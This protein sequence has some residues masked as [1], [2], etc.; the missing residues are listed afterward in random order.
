MSSNFDFS[1]WLDEAVRTRMMFPYEEPETGKPVTPQQAGYKDAAGFPVMDKPGF[2]R[3][4]MS[5]IRRW[6]P[7]VEQQLDK[8]TANLGVHWV[9]LYL[10]PKPDMPTIDKP[11]QPIPSARQAREM[12]GAG[13][14]M[15]E[16]YSHGVAK[17]ELWDFVK[18]QEQPPPSPNNTIVYVK[19]TSRVHALS[20]WQLEHN[21]GHAVWGYA[22]MS[23]GGHLKAKFVKT[24]RQIIYDLQQKAY[25]A[26]GPLPNAKEI[27]IVLAR[28]LKQGAAFRRCFQAKAG[29]LDKPQFR[30]N[31]AFNSFDEAMFDLV[32][33][34]INAGGRIPVDLSGV[35]QS[36]SG[37]SPRSGELPPHPEIE[38]KFQ[39]R[40]W[41]WQKLASDQSAWQEASNKLSAIVGEAIQACV[42]AKIGGPVYATS[43]Y[44]TTSA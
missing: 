33:S 18:T 41:V 7:E 35:I 42:W 43:G 37:E 23:N 34:Y 21:I 20:K 40:S 15:Y 29:D 1:Q 28:V 26:G 6:A 5:L 31:T 39:P 38:R 36:D 4:D 12:G 10:P 24:L 9:L 27:T 14:K 25:D 19:P 11:G 16:P 22:R 3:S 8:A 32:A 17:Q 44:I 13:W 2:R 30:V